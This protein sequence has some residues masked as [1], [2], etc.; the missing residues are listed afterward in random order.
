V[1][2][3]AHIEVARNGVFV[4]ISLSLTNITSFVLKIVLSTLITSN[5]FG[6]NFFHFNW[7]LFRK[8]SNVWDS[9]IWSYV[10]AIRFRE[11]R[12][13]I[14]ESFWIEENFFSILN[15]YLFFL[16]IRLTSKIC[17]KLKSLI[18]FQFNTFSENISFFMQ[19]NK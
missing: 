8:L 16:H 10:N 9:E 3:G 12:S 11:K 17:I 7:K 2:I 15:D 5:D 18:K 13:K 1:T 4:N 6:G 19:T 14:F